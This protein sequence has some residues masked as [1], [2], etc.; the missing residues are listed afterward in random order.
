M[1]IFISRNFLYILC[2][3][4]LEINCSFFRFICSN[5]LSLK[6][7]IESLLPSNVFNLTI[8]N[9]KNIFTWSSFL[10]TKFTSL[11]LRCKVM[12]SHAKNGIFFTRFASGLASSLLKYC[13]SI[14][15]L[16]WSSFYGLVGVLQ[17]IASTGTDDYFER[18]CSFL[19]IIS[20]LSNISSFMPIFIIQN[21]E[22][23][24]P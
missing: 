19:A 4:S 24:G 18:A 13:S 17:N 23:K 15:P 1:R 10:I 2:I 20:E 3:S 21:L 7:F 11:V 14:L 6:R 8:K 22:E 9:S 5:L 12:H 16:L